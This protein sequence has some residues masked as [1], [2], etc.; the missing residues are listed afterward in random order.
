MPSNNKPG[1]QALIDKERK[2]SEDI[3]RANQVAGAQYG[4][5]T[6]YY[7]PPHQRR[8]FGEGAREITGAIDTPTIEHEYRGFKLTPGTEETWYKW[9]ISPAD[10][11]PMPKSLEGLWT[12]VA[13][14]E[15]AID[16]WHKREDQILN[17]KGKN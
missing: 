1:T 7:I 17:K 14:A 9:T 15:K 4:E 10:D 12:G 5:G 8:A 6:R 16:E 3:K 13:S 2:V 11:F